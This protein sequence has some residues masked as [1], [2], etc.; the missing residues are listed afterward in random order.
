MF[1]D[2]TGKESSYQVRKI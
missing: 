2:N 1:L